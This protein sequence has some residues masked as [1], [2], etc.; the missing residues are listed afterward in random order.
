[1]FNPEIKIMYDREINEM[2]PDYENGNNNYSDALI[3]SALSILYLVCLCL[4]SYRLLVN[5]S[6]MLRYFRVALWNSLTPGNEILELA[7]I[8]GG[9]I[10]LIMMLYIGARV[11][12]AIAANFDKLKAELSE[13]D[14]RI[15]ALTKEI[16]A[17]RTGVTLNPQN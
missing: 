17:L 10:T 3:P 15:E 11:V 16:E 9:T 1:M 12:D 2:M 4:L 5:F 8:I 7:L 6:L 14:K 13:K